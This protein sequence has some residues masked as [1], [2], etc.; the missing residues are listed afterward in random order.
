MY[1]WVGKIL[2]VDLTSGE[3]S[4][5]PTSD[6]VPKLIGGR[7]MGA[8]IYWEEVPPEC[9]AFD[10]ENRLIMMTGP[11]TGTLAPTSSRFYIGTKS[12]APVNECYTYSVPG[13]HWG[14]YLKFTGYDGIVIKGKS[15]KPVY[16]W[17]SDGKAEIRSAERLWGMTTRN[18]YLELN[19]LHGQKARALVI[20]PGGENLCR[21]AVIGTDASH[22]AGTGGTGAVMGSK[23]LKAI[24]VGGTGEVK[25]ARPKE[26]IALFSY[27]S[28]LLNRK[29]GEEQYPAVNKSMSY[30]MYHQPHIP[31]C[32]GH[33]EKPADPAVYFKNMGLDDPIN[34][35]ADS[36]KKG[37]IK[38]KWGGCYACPVCC[39]LTYQSKDVDIPSGSGKCNGMESWPTYEWAGHKKVV[40]IPSIWFNRYMEDLG[41]SITNTCG[42]HFYWFFDL[43]KLGIL[44]EENTGVPVDKP[45]TLEFIKGILEKVAYRRGIGDQLA[46]GQER[47]LKSLS[48]KNPAAKPIYEE[49]IWHPG[50]FVHWTTD[51]E[52]WRAVSSTVGTL[53][54]ATETR[55]TMN[56]VSGGFAKSGMNISGLTK[57]EQKEL[58]KRGNMKYFGAENATDLPGEPKT[59]ENKVR[60]VIICQNLSVNMDCVTMCGWA[61]CPP[62]YSRYTSDKLGD[63]AQ[64]AK[65]YSAVTGIDMTHDEMVEAMNPIFNIERCIHVR[66]GRR[67][68]HDVYPDLV[69]NLDSW[70]WTSKEEFNKV[71]DEY[72]EARGWDIETGIPRKS[73]LEKLG[74]KK[75]ADEMEGKYGVTVPL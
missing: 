53:I 16:L 18:T 33:P 54:H 4:E 8:M 67:R 27:Y 22:A 21:E 2:R 62:F 3:M 5:T 43:V 68:E 7:G 42:Y 60:T 61:N 72:Y 74:L 39:V 24:V 57:G 40:G 51:G 23:K 10:P 56:K 19:M 52:P 26:L 66:E 44:T 11:T 75:I 30:Y 35:M 17:I 48:D 34:L 50:Y 59:W 65:M 15:P 41:L 20:G 55:T 69:Y 49:T 71:M 25:V 73:T 37:L 6:Y 1:G 64:G 13:G 63:P 45:W 12:P 36:V 58:L 38:M 9:G 47:F 31:F 32:P 28:R 29:P 46:E 14:S 70:K